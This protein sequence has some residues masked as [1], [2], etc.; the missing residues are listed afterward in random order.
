[1]CRSHSVFLSVVSETRDA[2]ARARRHHLVMVVAAVSRSFVLLIEDDDESA[3]VVS[4]RVHERKS[5]VDYIPR[6]P[7]ACPSPRR[8]HLMIPGP[9]KERLEEGRTSLILAP[10]V[11]VCA[12]E[13]ARARRI[14]KEERVVQPVCDLY[15]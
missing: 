12:L 1:M 9:I 3:T 6:E 14:A 7:T 2:R 8:S 5:A 13:T 10:V 15:R 4:R 11:A